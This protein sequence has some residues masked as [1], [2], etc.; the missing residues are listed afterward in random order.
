MEE[1]AGWSAARATLVAMVPPL[2]PG[3]HLLRRRDDRWQVGLDPARRVLLPPTGPAHPLET[4]HR[5]ALPPPGSAPPTVRSTLAAVVRETGDRCAAVLDRRSDHVIRVETFGNPASTT[6]GEELVGLCERTGLRLPGPARPGPRP[7]RP[8]DSVTVVAVVGVGEP[9]REHLDRHVREEAPHL[10]V[11]LVEGRA[12]LGPFVV[13]GQTP[14]LRCIDAHLT[15][16]DASWPLLVEQYARAVRRERADGVPE[17]VDAA[18]A[19]LALS[20][21]ARDLATYA[22]GGT[23]TTL[24]STIELAPRLDTVGTERWSPHPRCGCSWG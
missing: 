4:S 3:A 2:A 5:S 9:S 7:R 14:C 20:W 21:A 22:E 24:A 23:P 8:R 15:D 16:A 12:V 11:R 17:P 18:L 13:P 10:L 6:L 1:P 19:S